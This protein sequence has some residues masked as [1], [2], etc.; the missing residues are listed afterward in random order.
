MVD[1]EKIKKEGVE[2]LE[3]FSEKLKDIPETSE[4]HYVVDIKNVFRQDDKPEEKKNFRKKI[5]SNAPKF[6]E[7]CVVAEKGV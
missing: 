4:T 1:A 5:K 3:E 2:L 7:G 6:E